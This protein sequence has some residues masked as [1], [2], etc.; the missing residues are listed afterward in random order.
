MTIRMHRCF[1]QNISIGVVGKDEEFHI[2]SDEENH[3]YVSSMERRVPSGG[4]PAAAA[5]PGAAAAGDEPAGD[6]ME[7]H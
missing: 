1:P 4:A 3:L 5:E 7:T 2:L 6:D